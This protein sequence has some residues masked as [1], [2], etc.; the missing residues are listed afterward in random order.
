METAKTQSTKTTKQCINDQLIIET[1]LSE[2]RPAIITLP[3]DITPEEITMVEHNIYQHIGDNMNDEVREYDED[4][5]TAD[6][7]P[8]E[9]K[10]Y[11]ENVAVIEAENRKKFGVFIEEFDNHRCSHIRLPEM[12]TEE[13][14]GQ[15]KKLI[16]DA[17][18]NQ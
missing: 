16:A 14:A 17:V 1:Q 8:L 3:K 18:A 6:G 5:L 4:E 9:M 13:E 11:G 12:L 7:L 2:Y 15:I 10:I